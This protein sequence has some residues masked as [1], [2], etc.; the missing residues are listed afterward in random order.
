MSAPAV[1]ARGVTKVYR[2]FLHKNQF[3]TLKSAL[4]KGSLLSDL[5][6]EDTFT[7]LEDVSFEVA[8]GATFGVIGENGSGKSTLLKLLAGITKPTR[9]SLS[10]EGRVSALIELGAG[11][12]PEISGREN[13]AINGIMLGLTRQQ[14]E[15]RFDAIVDFAELRQFIDAPV[16]TYSSGMYMRLGFAV[17]IHVDPEVLLID[18]VLA[19]GDE[20][21]TRKCLDKI[22]E[23][24]RRGKTILLVTHSLGLVERMCD[25]VLWL[26]H[27][28]VADRGD[29]KRVVDAYLT[30]VAGG[31]EALLAAEPQPAAGAVAAAPDDRAP[32]HG[33][34]EGR[35]GSRELEIVA[36]RVLDDRA[37]P[38]HVYVPGETLVVELDVRAEQRCEDFVFGIGLFTADGVSVYG[39]NTHLEGFGP[40]AASGQGTARIELQDLRLVEGT[41]LLDVAVHRRDGTPFDYHR[42]LSTF[43]VKS[44][45][46]DV[47]I[48]RP[49]HQWSFSGGLS[50][51]P[52]QPRPELDLSDEET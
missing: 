1:S 26:R 7:A 31:E 32:A 9:G 2:R 24:R 11:F 51:R 39:T 16:K 29:P 46:K 30:Y 37:R 19:V 34:R 43:R 27:G 17:A 40:E 41:Y 8:R 28:R 35:W 49:R 20:A 4:L 6:P 13:V 22:G 48:Y 50:L 14:V 47:G 45:I 21:F 12:H 52:P 36:V 25:D 3:K 42:G 44:R 18:E 23:F 38:R 15:E 5:A 10:V 33:Y